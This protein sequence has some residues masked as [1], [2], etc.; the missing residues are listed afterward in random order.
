VTDKA[1]YQAREEVGLRVNVKNKGTNFTLSQL[2]VQVRMT[3]PAGSLRM[4]SDLPV[5][6]L[7]PGASASLQTTWNTG[8]T[9]PGDYRAVADVYLGNQ[10]LQSRS[11]LFKVNPSLTLTGTVAATPAA[12]FFDQAVSADYTVQNTGNIDGSGIV[13]RL[14]VIDPE[15]GTIAQTADETIDLAMGAS[16]SGR[17]TIQTGTLRLKSYLISLQSI[18][19]G[20][21]TNL[22]QASFAVKDGTAPVISIRSP[23]AEQLITST[24]RI[25]A[26][27]TDAL[28][29]V[30]RVEVEIAGAPWRPVP[31]ADLSQGRYV[32]AWT[33][34]LADA[35]VRTIRLRATD[36]AGNESV[37]SVSV[38]VASPSVADAGPDQT[39]NEGM[40]VTLDGSGSHASAGNPLTYRWEQVAGPSVSLNQS[41]P[42]HP[43]FVSPGVAVGGAT[44][45]FGLVVEEDGLSSAQDIVNVTVKNVNHP[46]IAEAGTD[47]A[48]TEGTAVFLDGS[49]SF[50][51]D[52]EGIAYHWIQTSGPPVGLSD[53]T[54]AR[55]SFTAPSVTSA[56]ATL[57]FDLTV[58]D[59]IDQATDSVQ[60][61]VEAANHPPIANA[62]ADQTKDEGILVT[63]DGTNSSDPDGDVLT[64]RWTQLGGPAVSLSDPQSGRPSFTAPLV[65]AGGVTLLFQLVVNDGLAGSAPDQVTVT[66]LNRNDPPACGQARP[67][68]ALL[69]PPNHKLVEITLSGVTD[70]EN[71]PVTLTITGVTQDE[72]VNGTG[73]GDTSPDAVIQGGKVL[74]RAERSGN[75]NGRVYHIS[76]T[77]RDMD[78]GACTG[79]VTVGVPHNNKGT[80]IDGGQGYDSTR[81]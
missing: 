63:L 55:P 9:A 21:P 80:P 61:H 39:V 30:D 6:S 58:T 24:V 7:L 3:D 57:R 48:V 41:D 71:D 46:P 44:L 65:S 20:T 68:A 23:L 34:V 11:V 69:W 32:I 35:G 54:T 76:F 52:G 51:Q 38:K 18:N 72:P 10:L 74:L 42:V 49:S 75:G 25:E 4:T 47:Q 59:G 15:T 78:G 79:F 37:A 56:G 8:L 5:S 40:L 33:P 73:D 81:P 27:V 45:T 64:Y 36:R 67:S 1:G 66:V 16:R 43:A 53:P 70:P 12:V 50:D 28:S 19:Q 31:I 17:L 60:V 14:R 22:G 29:G 62:G 77:A 2:K 26:I 13:L